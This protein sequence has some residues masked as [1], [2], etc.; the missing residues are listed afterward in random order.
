MATISVGT[1]GQLGT[2]I[3]NLMHEFRHDVFVKRLKWKLPAGDEVERDQY[4][5]SHARYVVVSDDSERITACARLLPTTERYMLPELFPQLLGD[6]DTPRDHTIWELSRFA[7]TVRETGEGRILSLSKPTLDFLGLVLDF[8]QRHNIERLIFVTSI[9]IERLMLRAGVCAHRLGPPAVVDGHLTV[10][11]FIEVERTVE[12]GAPAP[13]SV[14]LKM[15][16]AEA[17]GVVA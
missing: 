17:A 5:T 11:L 7:T 14:T 6:C 9:G 4:D 13:A 2:R 3:L 12:A 1:C 10:A 8:A 15:T 16:H